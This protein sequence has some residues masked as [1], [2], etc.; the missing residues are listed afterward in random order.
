MEIEFSDFEAFL[1]YY[2][3]QQSQGILPSTKVKAAV[4]EQGFV[5]SLVLSFLDSEMNL[6]KVYL[7]DA[8]CMQKPKLIKEMTL[9]SRIKK[10]EN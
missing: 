8:S 7:Y 1:E 6:C 5:I 9:H 3:K 4:D 10:E 2:Y